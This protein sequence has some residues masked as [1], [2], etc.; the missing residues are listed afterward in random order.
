MALFFNGRLIITPAV[1]SA[2]D[3][4]AMANRNLTVGNVVAFI[5][6][7]TGGEPKTEYRFGNP[8]EARAVLRSGALLDAIERAFDPSSETGAPA[9]VVGLRVNPATQATLYLKDAGAT[10]VILLTS[11]DYGLWTNDIKVKVEAA[12]TKGRKLTTQVGND[13]YSKDDVYRD[14]FEVQYTGA[15][16]SSRMSITGTTLTLEAPNS[17]TVATIDLNTYNTVQKVVDRINAT[18]GFEASVLDGNGEKATLNALDYV[19]NQDVKSAAYTATAHLQAIV[20]WF[21]SSSEGFVT[22]TRQA[23]VGALPA[24]IGFTYLSGAVDGT[25]TNNDWQ[26]A[27]DELQN[28]DV[29]WVTPISS[30]SS[31]HAMCD[32]HCAY[33]SNIGRKERRAIC[34]T[35]SGTSDSDAI[36]AAK[37]LNSDRTSLVHLGVYDYDSNGDLSLFEPYI[38]AAMIAGAFSGSNPGTALTN[39]SLKVRGLERRLRNPTDTDALITGGV[40]CVEE[41]ETGFRVVKSISTWLNNDNYNRVEQSTGAAVDFA[42]RNVRNAL[43]GI[44]GGKGNVLTLAEAYTRVDTTLRELAKPEPVGPGVLAGDA[45]NPA[46]KNI[47]LSLEG[48]VLRVEFQCSPVIPVNYVSVVM[49]AVPFSGS[50]AS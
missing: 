13:Y 5:G 1:V 15:Q 6:P 50:I 48:D 20:D 14:V 29:Q 42:I 22:A 43:E 24:V 21:N 2:V 27:F 38:L 25:I 28:I 39:K 34:G 49:H 16:A 4:S 40:L 32:T 12:T 17:T 35:A 33:M 10:N 31:I 47:T 30:S 23:S 11:T 46:Y 44:K 26:D 37:A 18:S 9:T 8:S 36:T 45:E 41:T 7:A 3:D 19:S